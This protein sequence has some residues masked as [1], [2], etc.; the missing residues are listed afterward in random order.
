LLNLA[1]GSFVR[2]AAAARKLVYG[3]SWHEADIASTAAIGIK[4]DTKASG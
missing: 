2:I 1:T 3:N 4:P